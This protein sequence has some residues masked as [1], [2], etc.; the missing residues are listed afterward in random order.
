MSKAFDREI[1]RLF[2]SDN[3][4]VNPRD[5]KLKAK[6]LHEFIDSNLTKTQKQ[7]IILYYKNNMKIC[8]IARLYNVAPSTVSRTVSR[9]RKRLYRGLTGR[10]LY[11]RYSCR[12]R[13]N[14]NDG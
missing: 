3:S 4:P 14:N 9:A 11:S 6:L 5:K 12:E 7:Y 8:E 10:E 2:F 13:G 1:I